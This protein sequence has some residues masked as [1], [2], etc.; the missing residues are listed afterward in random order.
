MA[1]SAPCRSSGISERSEGFSDCVIAYTTGTGRS[2][3]HWRSRVGAPPG[4]DDAVDL[5]RQQRPDV[6]ILADRV[7]PAVAQ[8]D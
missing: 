5:A 2:L 8:H 1:S 6:V 7:A 4:H 3:R